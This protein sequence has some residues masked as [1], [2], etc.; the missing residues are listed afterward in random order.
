MYGFKTCRAQM[1]LTRRMKE[2]Q[3]DMALGDAK[4]AITGGCSPHKTL[5]C[6]PYVRPH[7]ECP[8]FPSP[9]APS[10]SSSPA[11]PGNVQPSKP[12]PPPPPLPPLLEPRSARQVAVYW[13]LQKGGRKRR[14]PRPAVIAA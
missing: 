8:S 4:V 6:G 10:R 2:W 7:P 3:I 12:P 11:S 5:W 9:G 13:R 14:M 1:T